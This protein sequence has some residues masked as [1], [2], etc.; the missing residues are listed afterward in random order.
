MFA[1]PL[2]VAVQSLYRDATIT[3]LERD[4]TRIAAFVPDTVADDPDPPKLPS[5]LSKRITVGIY[6]LSGDLIW[7]KGPTR[8]AVA[9]KATDRGIHEVVEDGD[10]AVSAP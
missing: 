5:G 9:T 7:G 6:D 1:L 8:S 3:S 10:L 4:A 2:A